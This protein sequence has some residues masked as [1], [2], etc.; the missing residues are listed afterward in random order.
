VITPPDVYIIDRR[1]AELARTYRE[2]FA[3]YLEGNGIDAR[4]AGNEADIA[5][6]RSAERCMQLG[7]TNSF[8]TQP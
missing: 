2:A 7:A 8:P 4:E 5:L 1:L 6:D 3:E